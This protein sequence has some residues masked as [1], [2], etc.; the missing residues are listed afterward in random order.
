MQQKKKRKKFKLKAI[1]EF[2]PSAKKIQ[3]KAKS[4]FKLGLTQKNT[5]E[6]QLESL[7]KQLIILINESRYVV[8]SPATKLPQRYN[9]TMMSKKKNNFPKRFLIATDNGDNF[10][11]V[12]YYQINQ[13]I[14]PLISPRVPKSS[15]TS[16]KIS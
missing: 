15:K 11:Y 14:L 13:L 12:T 9:K 8:V 5:T 10:Y 1:L 2:K 16:L 7:L 4:K 3:L 6:S